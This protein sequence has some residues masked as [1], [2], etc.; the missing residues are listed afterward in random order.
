MEGSVLSFL[1]MKGPQKCE[2]FQKEVEFLG[3]VVGS[4]GMYI[5]PRYVKDI[6]DWPRPNNN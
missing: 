2:L 1:R 6:E 3:R 5:G 4:R